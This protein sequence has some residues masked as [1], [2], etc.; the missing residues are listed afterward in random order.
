MNYPV[1][2]VP[3][4]GGGWII[5]IIAIIHVYLSHFAVG[6]GAFLAITEGLAYKRKDERIYQYLRQHSKFFMILTS[7]SGAVTGVAIWWAI[8]LVNPDGTAILIQNFTLAWALEYL[9]FVAE[10]ATV[11]VYYYSWDRISKEAHWKLAK[12]YCFLSIMTLV[13]INGILT[14]MLTPG[15]WIT[16]HYWLDG[17]LNPT[18][19][20]SL[21]MRLLIMFAIAGMYAMVTSSRLEDEELRAYM[22]KYCA[23][24]LLPI[25]LMGPLVAFWYIS[26]VPQATMATIFTGIQSSGVGNFSVLART[27][28]LSFILS[29]TIVLFAFFGPYL[30]PKGFTFRIAILFLI[31]GLAATGS[32]EYMRELLHKPYVVYNFVY[33]NGVHKDDVARLQENGFIT[34]GVWSKACAAQA[35]GDAGQGEVMFRYQC[36][37]CHTTNGYRSMKKLLG[38]RDEEAIYGFLTMLKETNPEKNQYLGIMPPLAGQDGELRQLAKYL[39]TINHEGAANVGSAPVSPVNGVPKAAV[40]VK[41]NAI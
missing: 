37:S 28:Y 36:M 23:K 31:C 8:A 9:F 32:T 29:G 1:W 25:F 4:L 35:P 18:Y 34:N 22:A 39:Y 20:P 11:F 24:W 33:S 6:G 3:Y 12:L 26:N 13:I 16:S 40:P 21:V 5:G 15:T 41:N 19:F 10:L 7:V 17:F 2:V 38:E 14:F 30:N 27:L